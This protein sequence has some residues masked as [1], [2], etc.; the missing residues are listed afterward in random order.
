[1]SRKPRPCA[2]CPKFERGWCVHLATMRQP[3]APSC[4]Y[5]RKIMNNANAADPPYGIG[6]DWEKRD[7]DTKRKAVGFSASDGER[8]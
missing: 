1:M 7:K 3:D 6:R 5:G 8:G 4:G 2:V